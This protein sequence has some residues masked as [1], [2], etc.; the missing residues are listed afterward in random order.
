MLAWYTVLFFL[1]T[2]ARDEL[3]AGLGGLLLTLACLAWL[4]EYPAW[5]IGGW[6]NPTVAAVLQ[7]AA[8]LNPLA[9][10]GLLLG[11]RGEPGLA[12]LVGL[13]LWVVGPVFLIGRMRGPGRFA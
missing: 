2:R 1:L 11:N 13:I 3:H 4:A 12:A 8:W 6:S 9:P 5:Q 10:A 7:W